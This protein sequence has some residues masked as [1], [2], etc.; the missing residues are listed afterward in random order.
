MLHALG[1]KILENLKLLFTIFLLLFQYHIS[2]LYFFPQ[3]LGKNQHS[4]KVY[5]VYH[6]FT[7]PVI[8][9]YTP[10]Q[11]GWDAYSSLGRRVK[12][13]LH[14]FLQNKSE[15]N[16]TQE[17]NPLNLILTL[18]PVMINFMC[19][20][21]QVM[22]L[23]YLVNYYLDISMKVFFQMKLLILNQQTRVSKIT[24]HN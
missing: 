8:L 10:R 16:N 12:E 2:I 17:S 20:L 1:F 7:H 3:N 23:K 13:S 6:S 14:S 11:R 4:R 18:P 15:E 9:Q 24:L 5:L 21:N 19:Q 22:V